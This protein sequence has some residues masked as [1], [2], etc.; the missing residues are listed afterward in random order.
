MESKKF[1][2]MWMFPRNIRR[3][4]P[5]K[6][7]Q[8]SSA[9]EVCIGDVQSQD[10][11]DELYKQLS[12]L[13]VKRKE[14]EDGS[15]NQGGFRT[16]LAQLACLGLFWR[17]DKKFYPTK[18]GK[19]VIAG[20]N[21][22]KVLRCQL[23]RMQYP[24][25]YGLGNNVR[26]SPT[27]KIKPFQFLL[28]LLNE[29]RL[30]YKLSC[31]DITVPV[32]FGQTDSD[33]ELCVSKIIELR[34]NDNDLSFVITD[35][36]LVRTPKRDHSDLPDGDKRD[37]ELGIVDAF[38]IANTAINYLRAALLIKPNEDEDKT[39]SLIEDSKLRKEIQPYLN[40]Q[41]I[42]PLVSGDESRWQQFYGRYDSKR[43]VQN[44]GESEKLDGLAVMA[45]NL[46]ISAMEKDP[47]GVDIQNF[48]K[49]LAGN[50]GKPEQDI[51]SRIESII[52]RQRTLER[53][54][55]IRASLSGGK[56]ALTLEKGVTNILKN[57]GFKQSRH[58][59]QLKSKKKRDGGFPDIY[60]YEDGM[61]VCGLGDTKA[62]SSYSF[63]LTDKNK[64]QTY[65]KDCSEEIDNVHPCGFFLYVAGGFS[66]GTESV[67][68]S[69]KDCTEK[70]GRPVSAVTVNALLDLNERREDG[71]LKIGDR[72]L[73]HELSKV[74]ETGDYFVS[75]SQIENELDL[76]G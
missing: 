26:I 72:E 62:T 17:K 71:F 47:Y 2:T 31:K 24:S 1:R 75:C 70:F 29:K 52:P 33:F 21:P 19:A 22:L 63:G 58:I 49:G 54:V 73:A 12:E 13:G 35:P 30:G 44:V 11:Q 6:L 20:K 69:L 34:S 76:R 50:L 16:Y 25:V 38:E 4:E 10:V 48:V 18:A 7:T 9:L 51:Y 14:N 68:S 8:I 15:T 32:V 60:I 3:I 43:G 23:L 56:E 36:D 66:R 59:G 74:F 37:L 53:D 27:L 64:L 55:L 45:R 40:E 28:R 57:L 42:Y 61:T 46:F 67:L 39:F 5:W 41:K 65:Y